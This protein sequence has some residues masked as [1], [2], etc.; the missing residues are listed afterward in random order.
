VT[1][2]LP[3]GG[4][5]FHPIARAE[6]EASAA[7]GPQP[8]PAPAPAR[9]TSRRGFIGALGAAAGAASVGVATALAHPGQSA[10]AADAGAAAPA[11]I[12]FHGPHQAG[13][14]APV[15]RA[16]TVLALDVTATTRDGLQSLLQTITEKARFLT[17]GG[18]APDAGISAQPS[19]SGILGEEV[20]AG[21]LTVTLSVGASLFD[22]RFGLASAKPAKLRTMEDF[23]NDDLDRAICDGDLLLQLEADD[24]DVVTHAVREILRATRAQMQLR[25]KHDGFASPPRPSGTPRNLMGF[26]DGTAN[27]QTTDKKAMDQLVWVHGGANGEPAWAEGGSYVAVRVIRMLVE[28]W[29]RIGLDEQQQI[30]GRFRASGAPLTGSAE[31]DDPHYELDSTGSVIQFDAHIRLAN[32]R[33]PETADQKM[34]RRAHNYDAGVDS[35][36]NLDQGLLFTAYNQDLERQFVTVQKRLADEPLVDYISPVGGGYF[37]ALPG[38]RNGSDW[39]GRGL[40]T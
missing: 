21:G 38:A 8:A 28:F 31:F 29:D 16:T 15:R 14:L 2:Q 11:K 19:D 22:G 26:K 12:A 33:T 32:P 4:C 39:L 9:T 17:T 7:T 10:A 18:A 27:P 40:F 13:I 24:T 34:L 35:N 37:F 36:G 20:V 1:D 23:P 25:W 6:A 5:P 3:G 30:F